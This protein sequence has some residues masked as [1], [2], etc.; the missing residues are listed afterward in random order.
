M[1]IWP[2]AL[3]VVVGCT[4]YISDPRQVLG[5]GGGGGSNNVGGGS[6]GSGGAGGGGF[7]MMTGCDPTQYSSVTLDTIAT[8]FESNVYPQMAASVG[9]CAVCHAPGMGRNFTF[10]AGDS[11]NTFYSAWAGHFFD[12]KPGTILDR[13]TT[14]NATAKMPQG[15]SWTYDEILPVARVA[16]EL[17]GYAMNGGAK[18]D[19]IFPPALLHPYTGAPNTDYDDTFV[20]YVQLKAKVSAVFGDDWVRNGT[21]E[22]AANIGLFGGVDFTSHFVEARTATPEFLLGLDVMAPDVCAKA[23]TA[24]AAPF[25]NID[26]TIPIVDQP[27]SA[28]TQFEAEGSVVTITPPTGAGNTQG[29]PATKYLCYTNCTISAGVDI[30]YPGTY[31]V[32]VAVVPYP[33]GSGNGPKVE[34]K[35]G[36]QTQDIV[37]SGTT[38]TT[39]TATFTNVPAGAMTPVSIAYVN[40]YSDPPVTSGDRNVSFDNF[41]VDGPQGTST[42][43]T[44]ATQA[45]GN[46]DLLY[47]R[48]LYRHASPTEQDAAYSLLTDLEA[49]DGTQD[50]YQGLCEA[51]VRHPDFLFT[52]AP[53]YDTATGADKQQLLLNKLAL[54]LLGRPPSAADFTA[55]AGGKTY[56]QFV[57]SYLASPDFQTWFFNRAQLRTESQATPDTDEPA[58]LWT[59]LAV[60]DKPMSDLLV[61]EYSVDTTLKQV[62]RAAYY[63]K[64]GVLSMKGFIETK[65][66]LPHYNYA[67]RVFT[68]MMGYVFEIPPSVFD[69]RATSTAATTVDPTSIC[70]NCHQNL[71]PLSYQRRRWD[72]TG[73]YNTTDPMTG[74]AIDDTDANLVDSYEYKGHGLEA[75][76]TQAIHKESFIRQTLN[77][78]YDL[79]LGRNLRYAD[80][81]RD[82]YKQL[83][84]TAH[85]QGTFKAVL[86]QIA[87]SN[88]YRR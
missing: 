11:E 25:N 35:L 33:D 53:S 17:K 13:L 47:Q 52:L 57:D 81:E 39:I 32:N 38:A 4:G 49:I 15:G 68:D 30:A 83:W 22:F 74:N 3:F 54:D 88:K 73:A 43:T 10:Y 2:V 26:F 36:S 72:D 79:M 65:K 62:T 6:G 77:S 40:D 55:M 20:N 56:E 67:A 14:T 58:R 61:G 76:A 64:S 78:Q 44:R 31:K 69:Q 41:N 82:V 16:C 9:G 71:T 60:N 28:A 5:A 84:D 59:Y 19:E 50:A 29:N 70:F 45:K 23:A 48:M 63:G 8:D 66:G 34:V 80:D 51:L 18:P 27:A 87:L 85:S 1:R 46:A 12:D 86:K 21:D 7:N 24:G 75:F 37:V 42:G